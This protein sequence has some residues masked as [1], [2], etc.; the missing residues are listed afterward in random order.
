M[1]LQPDVELVLQ[2]MAAMGGARLSSLTPE[3]AREQMAQLGAMS[4]KFM[5]P[6]APGITTE[7]R[8]IAASAGAEEILVRIYT[9][10][11]ATAPQP[12]L[13][14]F[15][16]GGW[17]VGN[18]AIY[19]R[20][21]R[22]LVRQLGCVVVS[23]DYRLAPEHRFP[24]AVI[25]C[26]AATRWVAK[27]AAEL[28]IDGQRLGVGGDSAG[29][30]LAAVVAQQLRNSGDTPDLIGQL[31]IYPATDLAGD[32]AS[33]KEPGV[34]LL[35]PEDTAWFLDHYLNG[36]ADRNDPRAS[37]LRAASLSGL[38]AAV[39][40]LC[41]YDP[42]RDEGKAYA[43]ALRAAGVPTTELYFAGHIHGFLNFA[44]ILPSARAAVEEIC[45]AFRS[46]LHKT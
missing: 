20:E 4:A 37:P 8:R 42:L 26:V 33:T 44:A 6:P 1:P 11:G 31:L 43:A 18:V 5:G 36:P 46:I 21:C 27:H 45:A 19:D 23:V 15:H 29:G 16:G 32:Y 28:G 17:V 41:E 24:A 38:P 7:D 35:H 2:Q 22:E 40:A 12:G 3:Q 14:Y 10:D 9:P 39:V 13:V 25:D 34:G 30:N